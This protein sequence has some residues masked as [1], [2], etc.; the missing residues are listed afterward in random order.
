M[1]RVSRV[2]FFVIG[3]AF[4]CSRKMEGP[5]PSISNTI[6]EV[7]ASRSPAVVCNAQ[8]NPTAGWLVDIMGDNFSPIPENVLND[9][10]GT[11]LP[12]VSLSGPQS[13]SLSPSQ[14]FFSDKTKLVIQLPTKDS[15]TS[16]QLTPGSYRLTVTNPDGSSVSLDGAITIVPPPTIASVTVL[17]PPL[18]T[19][20]GTIAL[21]GTNFEPGTTPKVTISGQGLPTVTLLNVTVVN[22][23]RVTA[24]VPANTPEGIY[25]VTI[26]NPDGCSFTLPHVFTISYNS[27]GALALDPR[28]GWQLKNQGI[29]IYNTPTGSQKT[30]SGGAPQ[31]WIVA[32]LKT[33]PTI[34]VEIPLRRIA[35]VSPTIITAAVPDCSG[36]NAVPLTDAT[37]ANGIQPGGPYAIKIRDPNGA[38]GVITA[39]KGF[40]VLADPP[41]TITSIAPASIDTNGLPSSLASALVVTG[42]NFGTNAELQLVFPNGSGGTRACN[43]AVTASSATSIQAPVPTSLPASSCVEFDSSGNQ[44][45]ATA[46]FT[47]SVGLYVVRVQNTTNP[48][49]AN[50]SG[51]IV[52]E[53]SL[54]PRNG[55]PLASELSVARADFPLVEASDDLGNQ[56]MYA[57]GGTDGSNVLSSVE[58]APVT[59]FGDLGGDCSSS[60][61]KF[62]LLDRTQIGMG[63]MGTSPEPRRGM[64]AVVRTVANDTSYI[65]LIGGVNSSGTALKVVERAQVLKAADAPS[66]SAPDTVAGG[67]LSAGTF[68]Y[69]VSA[70]QSA[71]NPLNPGGETLASD[72]QPITVNAGV[73]TTLSW[74]CI[75]GVQKY[76]VYRTSAANAISGTE[77][78]LTEVTPSVASCTG[79]PLPVE[80][81]VDTGALTPGG[82]KPLPAG[83]LGRW[84]SEPSLTVERGNAAAK[85]VGDQLWVAGGFCSTSPAPGCSAPGDLASV[86]TAAFA[87]G[88]PALGSFSSAGT[89]QQARRRFAL[90][91][92]D[93]ATAP[94][95]F[96]STSPNNTKD[97]WLVVVGGDS[98]GVVVTGTDVIEVG[99][100]Q[101]SS[102]PIASPSFF[103][104]GYIALGSHGGWS[105]I[106]ANDIFDA[107]TTSSDAF[108][109]KSNIACPSSP[110]HVGQCTSETSFTGTLNDTGISYLAGGN[111]YLGGETLFRA[112]VY[113]AGGLPTDVSN[114][115]S[116]TIERIIY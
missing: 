40:W 88:S 57:L 65:Y 90:T 52:T 16:L 20:D 87:V 96:T 86:D 35:Y 100:V 93:A 105:E 56:Y 24:V 23:T 26:T 15:A 81:Y 30:F 21:D 42:Q 5:S 116:A 101:N 10:P 115:P 83:A 49:Y 37:C 114:T 66:L 45:A 28:F 31:G 80:T 7:D 61:C 18:P 22:A 102:G 27:L 84:A 12:T 69:R 108:A 60:P 94:S 76:R 71:S 63:S 32:P 111:R 39:A 85:L 17:I 33:N 109:F 11:M 14:V 79:S 4:A 2:L 1:Q 19:S 68:Y 36:L 64:A 41:P 75:P 55:D 44:T 58:V 110:G 78:L 67:N 95:S 47:L 113:V 46:G 73:Q 99:H 82:D 6:N 8:G 25:D 97:A 103:A 112:F 34:L 38:V 89:L 91:V 107:G 106:V 3:L 98:A 72:E 43:L 92:A 74:T 62:H 77:L 59:L 70:V 9:A 51:L 50:Y 54:N 104:S 53:P 48:A 13:Y 29:T